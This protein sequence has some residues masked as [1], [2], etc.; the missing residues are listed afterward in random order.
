M[1][2]W[3]ILSLAF[4]LKP[5]R[6]SRTISVE[7]E[8]MTE[9]EEPM[10]AQI[11]AASTNPRTPVGSRSLSSVTNVVFGIASGEKSAAAITARQREDKDRTQFQQRGKHCAVA[12]LAD[13]LR[14]QYALHI[15]LVHA[16]I[17]EPSIKRAEKDSDEGIVGIVVGLGYVHGLRHFGDQSVPAADLDQVPM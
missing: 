12:R 11:S 7:I 14:S 9:S 8:F 10:S 15:H 1:V 17:E 2:T 4:L 13:I 3:A 16:P 6:K 5:R